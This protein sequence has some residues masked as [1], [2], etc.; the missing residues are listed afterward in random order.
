MKRLLGG[1]SGQF[2]LVHVDGTL[3]DPV[4]ST[5]AFPSLAAALQKL[6]AQR[7]G[8]AAAVRR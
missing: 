1:A 3:A 8:T 4:P 6:Q 7:P 5:E 2:M